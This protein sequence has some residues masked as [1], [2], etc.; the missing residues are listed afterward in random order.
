MQI[1]ISLSREAIWAANHLMGTLS[2][3]GNSELREKN[4]FNRALHAGPLERIV[5][6]SDRGEGE[7][8]F[9]HPE[10][11]LVITKEDPLKYIIRKTE[12]A[13]ED[14]VPGQISIGYE[15]L[16]DALGAGLRN[17]DEESKPTQK[18]E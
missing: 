5:E 16:L 1:E 9:S 12:K 17:W 10:R 14:G 6:K 2:P 13:I 7:R 11:P 4:Y 8:V 15:D 3:K 18:K